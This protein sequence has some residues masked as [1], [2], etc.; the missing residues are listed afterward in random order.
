MRSAGS[1]ASSFGSINRKVGEEFRVN[2]TTVRHEKNP[3]ICGLGKNRFVVV[4]QAALNYY[5][6]IDAIYGQIYTWDINNGV[7][8][9]GGEFLISPSEMTAT[10]PQVTNIGSDKFAVVYKN[11]AKVISQV[12]DNDGNPLGNRFVVAHNS[13]SKHLS[14]CSMDDTKFLI[15]YKERE[16][17]GQ[18]YEL[19]TKK[20]EI[21]FKYLRD[22]LNINLQKGLMIAEFETYDADAKEESHVYTLVPGDGDDDNSLFEIINNLLILNTDIRKDIY[23]FKIQSTNSAGINIFQ[24]FSITGPEKKVPVISINLPPHDIKFKLLDDKLPLT[25][26]LL[27]GN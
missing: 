26:N 2:S 1:E 5:V 25:K 16:L 24:S 23:R 7:K 27:V 12:F 10:S 15:G 13:N 20:H 14:I 8:K 3:S 11:V 17:F 4:W 22:L 9:K 18:F 6:E 21:V 19:T